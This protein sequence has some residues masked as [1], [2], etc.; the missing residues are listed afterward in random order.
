[1]SNNT[2]KGSTRFNNPIIYGVILNHQPF[3]RWFKLCVEPSKANGRKTLRDD[4]STRFRPPLNHQMVQALL[5]PSKVLII[6][7]LTKIG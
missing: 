7:F 3:L 4:G 1:M 2:N 6:N 5:E